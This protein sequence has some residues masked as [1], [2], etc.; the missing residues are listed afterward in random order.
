MTEAFKFTNYR[1][2]YQNYIATIPKEF[3]PSDKNRE[4]SEWSWVPVDMLINPKN[5]EYLF[6][7]SQYATKNV[8]GK[9]EDS[10][11]RSIHPGLEALLKDSTSQEILREI[12]LATD[13]EEI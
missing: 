5:P 8:G 7:E 11:Y 13:E 12:C 6:G 2:E 1:L 9:I 3:K 4:H 10:K